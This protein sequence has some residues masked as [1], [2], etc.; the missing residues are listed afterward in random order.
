VSFDTAGTF[1]N[2]TKC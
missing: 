1:Y 2:P